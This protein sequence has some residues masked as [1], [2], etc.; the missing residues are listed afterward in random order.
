MKI[1]CNLLI[2][3][4]RK[5]LKVKHIKMMKDEILSY[6]TEPMCS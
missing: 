5:L 3:Q 4:I 2:S 1:L 6:E